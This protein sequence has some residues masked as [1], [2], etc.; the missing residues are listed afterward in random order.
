MPTRE[1]AMNAL[2]ERVARARFDLRERLSMPMVVRDDGRDYRFSC[3]SYEEW[4]RAESLLYKE[5]GT[6]RLLHSELRP[7]DVFYD[8]GANMG[9]YSVPAAVAVGPEGRVF[10]F[11]PHVANA[12]SLLRNVRANGLQDRVKVLSCALNDA[13][14]FFEFHYDQLLAGTSQS[15]LGSERDAF[16]RT[17][18][19]EAS[20]LKFATT[21]DELLG[22]GAIAPPTV[23]K[24]DVDGN[25]VLILRGMRGLLEGAD[26][27]RA[28]QVEVNVEGGEELLRLMSECGFEL[29]ER[30][31]TEAFQTAL[32]GGADPAA[33]PYNGVFRPRG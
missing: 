6:M 32:D 22:A 5:P 24:I 14:G 20:E 9:I 27:P 17:L 33:I 25:E 2:R 7:G 8:V 16:G 15:Q 19:P 3:V 18:R 13:V 31:Y 21:I 26:R 1:S 12:E 23:V 28:V 4:V 10:A 11:E 30:H 29:A